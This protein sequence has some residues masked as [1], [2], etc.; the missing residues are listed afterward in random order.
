MPEGAAWAHS[1][2]RPLWDGGEDIAGKTL[3]TYAEQGLGDTLQFCRFAPLLAARG[4]RVILAVQDTLR[5]LL[6]GLGA[7]IEVVGFSD[8]PREFDFHCPL[9]SLPRV[10]HKRLDSI[11]ATVPYL[12]PDPDRVSIWR[13]RLGT[14]G[15]LIGIRWQG[16][17]GRADAGRSFPLRH[18]EPLA[19]IPGIRLISLQK[20]VGSEQLLELP[21]QW[22]VEDLG[23]AFEPGGGDAFLDV[24]AVMEC[25]ELII[26]S[27]TS[28]THLAGA[29]GR[30]TWLALKRV[31]DWR[32][33]LER[34]DSPWY[35]TVRCFRQRRTGDWE[36]VFDR[37]CRALVE[38]RSP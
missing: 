31:P 6:R 1:S 33:M 30:P 13:E 8:I 22:R 35:P 37:M 38:D 12:R 24:A 11:P 28:I 2:A 17:T 34:D 18:F 21:S 9:L 29:L 16:S 19:R 23:A 27:D 15:R 5:T 10:L 26:T 3:L 14:H 25:L 20:G 32:W 36:G 7:G 4:A